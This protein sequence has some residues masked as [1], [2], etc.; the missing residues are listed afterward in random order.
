[1]SIRFTLPRVLALSLAA[2]TPLFADPAVLFE[3]NFD[4]TPPYKNGGRLPI[5]PGDLQLGRWYSNTTSGNAT[6]LVSQE[7][8]LSQPRSLA[9]RVGAGTGEASATGVFAELPETVAADA[10]L[11]WRV[12]FCF[13]DLSFETS[14]FFAVRDT[15]GKN[16]ALV[17]IGDGGFLLPN[18]VDSGIKIEPRTWYTL[19]IVLPAQPAPNVKDTYSLNIS[20]NGGEQVYS[21]ELGFFAPSAS[22][23]YAYATVNMKAPSNVLFLDDWRVTVG[24]DGSAR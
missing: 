22:G 20:A 24:D 7:N 2:A 12:S 1:M 5:E 15:E 16:I 8:F 21:K 19:E 14:P 4:E 10:R 23:K 13:E 18:N 11:H 6:S 9:L 17:Y 3:A